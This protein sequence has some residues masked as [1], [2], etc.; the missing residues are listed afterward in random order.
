MNRA[1]ERYGETL[2][3]VQNLTVIQRSL[4]VEDTIRWA[5]E[6]GDSTVSLRTEA[7]TEE[8]NARALVVSILGMVAT[9]LMHGS[10]YR[11]SLAEAMSV[12]GTEEIDGTTTYVLTFPGR[13]TSMPLAIAESDDAETTIWI[14]TEDYLIRWLDMGSTD[15]QGESRRSIMRFRDF[16]DVDGL[17]YPFRVEIDAPTL[18]LDAV[19]DDA[20]LERAVAAV[21]QARARLPELS[22]TERTRLVQLERAV[23]FQRDLRAPI[24][25]IASMP[26][27]VVEILD[28]RFNLP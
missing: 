4:G 10:F 23:G 14:G 5:V 22:D 13:G 2:A 24:E 18:D 25:E 9:P 8:N 19:A 15:P 26:S 28:V 20:E 16:R 6:S 21:E 1:R 17:T 11:P 12:Q 7:P 3:S 27:L